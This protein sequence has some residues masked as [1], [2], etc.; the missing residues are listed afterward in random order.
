MPDPQPVPLFQSLARKVAGALGRDSSIIRFLRPMYERGLDLMTGG[1]GY[2]RPL[3]DRERFYI[4]PRH[5]SHFP[6][7]YDAPVMDYLRDRVRPGQVALNVGA[8]VRVYSLCLAEWLGPGGR[9][10]AFEPNPAIRAILADTA[11]RNGLTRFR[12][13][14]GASD[15]FPPLLSPDAMPRLTPYESSPRLTPSGIQQTGR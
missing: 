14:G 1:R 7:S 11:R 12:E 6:E 8:N 9:I 10:F 5:R 2:V 3:N 13:N 4:S 15:N